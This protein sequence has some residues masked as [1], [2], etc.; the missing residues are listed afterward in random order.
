MGGKFVRAKDFIYQMMVEFGG[1]TL[2]V[3]MIQ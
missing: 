2:R 1:M 3:K